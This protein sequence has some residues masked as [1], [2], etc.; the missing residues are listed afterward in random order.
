MHW[1]RDKA[2]TNRA[3]MMEQGDIQVNQAHTGV[4]SL[5]DRALCW[6]GDVAESVNISCLHHCTEAVCIDFNYMQVFIV[7]AINIL[8]WPLI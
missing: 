4:L 8:A 3:T 6:Y 5:R 2:Q 7:C 1:W